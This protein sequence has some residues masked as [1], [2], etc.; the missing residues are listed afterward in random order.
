ML[1]KTLNVLRL[2]NDVRKMIPDGCISSF[3][4]VKN[5]NFPSNS[6]KLMTVKCEI[7]LDSQKLM[8][9]NYENFLDSRKLMVA[10]SKLRS[11]AKMNININEYFVLEMANMSKNSQKMVK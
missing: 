10:K 7:F 6:R 1:S 2:V 11:F 3:I 8:V 4:G 9:A 5:L